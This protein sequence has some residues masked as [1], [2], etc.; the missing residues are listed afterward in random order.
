M[1][2][3]P[4]FCLLS[5]SVFVQRVCMS[6]L[7]S[8]SLVSCD[9]TPLTIRVR[10]EQNALSRVRVTPDSSLAF[11]VT[12]TFSAVWLLFSIVLLSLLASHCLVQP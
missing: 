11:I 4:A 8:S 7:T 2:A 10:C 1:Y 5:V 6:V 3:F 12:F 9:R